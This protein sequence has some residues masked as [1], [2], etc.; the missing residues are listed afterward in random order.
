MISSKIKNKVPGWVVDYSHP[1]VMGI[2][3]C[4]PD[5]FSDGGRFNSI[6]LAITR[7]D[8]MVAEGATMIDVGGEST[9]PG[10]DPVSVDDELNRVIPVLEIALKKFPDIYFS[11]DTTKY[12]VAEAALDLGVDFINDVSGLRKEP[13]FVQLCSDYDAGIIIM[14]SVGDPKTMQLDPN[15]SDVVTEVRDFLRSKVDLCKDTGIRNIIIDPGFGFGKSLDHNLELLRALNLIDYVPV[16]VGISR[17]SML[18]QLLNGR[19]TDGR[20]AATISAHFFALLQGAKILRVHDVQEAVDSVK[21][22]EA[23]N[24]SF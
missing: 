19:N 17:K 6:D 9:R 4:T 12:E 7:L 20:L 5:S 21:V 22:F 23:L 18:G 13:R 14:H 10:S 11:I 3:N 2:L 24:F 1:R 15:Y 8:T 16:L